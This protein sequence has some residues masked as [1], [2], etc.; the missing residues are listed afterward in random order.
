MNARLKKAFTTGYERMAGWADLMDEINVFPVADADTGRNLRVSLAPLTD[1]GDKRRVREQLLVGGVGNSGNIAAAFF[2]EFIRVEADLFLN[3]VARSG[4][5]AAWKA[6]AEPEP[7]TMLSVFDALAAAVSDTNPLLSSERAQ[8]LILA[9]RETVVATASGL[10]TLQTAGVVDSGALG[11]YLFFEGFFCELV[12]RKAWLLP[13]PGIFGDRVRRPQKKVSVVEDAYCINTLLAP[14]E[15]MEAATAKVRQMGT[16]VVAVAEAGRLKAHFHASD[17]DAVMENIRAIGRPEKWL[18]EKIGLIENGQTDA[19]KVHVA[20]DA[21]GSL[22]LETAK[23]MGIT[24]LDSYI[25]WADRFIPETAV[26]GPD[27]YTDMR[28]GTRVSTAQASAF[29]KDQRLE[30]LL[31]RFESVLYLSVGSV[32]TGNFIHAESYRKNH[33]E[34]HRL[35]V[36]DTGAASGRLGILAM[37]MA[38]FAGTGADLDAVTRHALE[39][40]PRC[41]AFLFLDQLKYLAAGGRISWAGGFFG[42]MLKIKPVITPT[43][44]G[45]EKVG[46]TQS[47]K[48]QVAFA[49]KRLTAALPWDAAV[50]VLLEY[51]DNEKWVA[52]EVVPTITERFPKAEIQIEP[53]SLTSGVHMGPGTWGVSFI[54]PSASDFRS[55]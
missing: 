1:I 49:L 48:G 41:E 19:G 52:S 7:G 9:M 29:E 28:H 40:I 10:P 45:A 53:L 12:D 36:V 35:R 18:V 4:A 33:G 47:T 31:S 38:R 51:S 43:A 15:D 55:S 37:A 25:V 32:Y 13:V 26:L 5:A 11:M 23:R 17:P 2:A 14:C 54:R 3:N 6:V 20:V 8:T 27:L 50:K 16:H 39:L 22:S 44:H 30:S 34:G 46:V 42:D 21:A 24:L